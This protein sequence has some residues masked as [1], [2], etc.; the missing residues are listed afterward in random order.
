MSE[1]TKIS[2]AEW[3]ICRVLWSHSPLTGNEIVA[4]LGNTTD[5]SPRTVK[6]L[7][8]RLVKKNILGYE[9]HG[10]EYHYFPRLSERE[11]VLAQTQSFVKRVFDGAAG[12]MVASFIE[13]QQLSAEE[14]D[15]L[16]QILAKKDDN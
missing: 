10:R 13:N 2:E 9:N 5:W 11:C 8:N 14:V 12:A 1:A 3:L 6:T 16:R 15:E 4:R 7:F